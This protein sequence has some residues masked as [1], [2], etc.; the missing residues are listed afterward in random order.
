MT[1]SF[2]DQNHSTLQKFAR[3]SHLLG[4]GLLVTAGIYF[5]L[6]IYEYADKKYSWNMY[7]LIIISGISSIFFSAVLLVIAQFLRSLL[8]PGYQTNWLFRNAPWV[9]RLYAA[10][11]IGSFLYTLIYTFIHFYPRH[12]YYYMATTNIPRLIKLVAEIMLL[13]AL[14]HLSQL[15][16]IYL[17]KQQSTMDSSIP[18]TL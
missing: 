1:Q 4:W 12:A 15:V 13:Y 6:Q 11:L 18:Q 16:I 17:H 9:F 8:N 7:A 5:I 14:A 3:L 10:V 2:F